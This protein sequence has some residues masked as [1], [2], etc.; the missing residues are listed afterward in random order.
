MRLLFL[1]KDLS[2]QL[3]V[4]AFILID[5]EGLGAPEKMTD[6]ESE[7]K[8]RILATFAMGVSN[9]TILNVLGEST[10]DLTEILQIAI[11]TM[12]RLGKAGM[13][14][15]ILMVQ[16]VSERNKAKMSEPEEKFREALQEALKITDEQYIEMGI[17]NTDC[18]QILDK[19]IQNGQLIKT[20]RPFKN[21]ATAYAPPSEQY[22]ED[23]VNLY[24]SII[25]DC[26][27]SQNKMEFSQWH[28]L[29]HNYWKEVSHENFAVRFKNIKEIYEF[30]VLGKRITKL[31][32][33]IDRSF[34]KHEESI[35]KKIRSKFLHWSP[36]DKSNINSIL[37]NEC[38]KLIKEELR[39]VPDCSI[40]CEDNIRCE[41]CVKTHEERF[42]LEKYLQNK[43]NEKCEM[44]TKQ[45]I[46]NYVEINRQSVFKKLTQILE[47]NFIRKGISSEF[48]DII[49]KQLENILKNMP[50]EGLSDQQR[51]QKIDEVWNLLQN[52]I[53]SKDCIIPI[54]EQIDNE[55]KEEYCKSSTELYH[56]Y[57]EGVIPDLCKCKAYK[58]LHVHNYNIKHLFSPYIDLNDLLVLE[59]KLDNLIDNIL[60]ERA[61]Y[62]FYHGIIR[63]LKKEISQICPKYYLPEFT[64]NVHLCALLM[65]KP[66]M[67]SYQEK[68][69]RENTPHGILNQKKDEYLKIIGTR[70][71]YGHTLI[72]EG[73]IVADYLASV[74]Y[75]K[76][77]HAGNNERKDAVRNI[78]WLTCAESIRLKY[79]E[80]LAEKVQNG[81]KEEAIR[82]FL[83]PKRSIESWFVRTINNNSSGNPEKKYE[84]TFNAEFKLVI[85]EIRN[86][87]SFEEIKPFVNDYMIQVDKVDY[88]LDLNDQITEN[89]LKIFQNTIER[90]LKN[91]A[92]SH[93]P[94]HE[95]FQNPSDDKSIMERLGCTQACH[96]CGALCW[97]SRDHHE[98]SDKTKIHH[99]SHQPAGLA[100]IHDKYTNELRA[101]PCHSRS[102]DT[103]MWY[104]NKSEP[105][106][107]S[108]A[109]VQDFSDWKFDPHY[110]H[111]FDDLMRWFFDKLHEDL[112]KRRN[113][114]PALHN[115]LEK[116]GCLDLDYDNII[117]VIKTKIME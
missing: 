51:E 49:N 59:S 29:I 88:K 85:Q 11:V 98:N 89:D 61:S 79:F 33:T 84:D 83:K 24:N 39:D 3:N 112:A 74:I 5:T 106:K 71:Q 37:R 50:V 67:I 117:S 96:W 6:P 60:K 65:F 35:M 54:E 22:H 1:E 109:K 53:S 18:L 102:D 27:N 68:W 115:D 91:K 108:V 41:E 92:N 25:N 113:L 28:S 17:S 66:K 9:L 10:R 57:K 99:S 34:Q 52:H 70:L 48:L 45:T 13:A 93:L 78:A 100:C 69:D 90:A 15:D 19:R 31:K 73:H 105:I 21:G 47:A 72:S 14:P 56:H 81:D 12:A 40:K 110:M 2:D 23:V 20:F 63:D 43:N 58:K 103:N 80:K 114:K 55:V 75:K 32:E 95:P 104:F 7:K 76:A 46:E 116:N 82:H 101:T 16:H 86:C 62:H 97:G 8:D 77:M 4:D 42:E 36:N 64:W 111:V 87:Q 38:S 26:K 44:E 94:R 30:I 107:W